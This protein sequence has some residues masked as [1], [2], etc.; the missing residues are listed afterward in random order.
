[1]TTLIKIQINMR[2]KSH[3]QNPSQLHHRSQRR[4]KRRKRRKLPGA[5][6]SEVR[7]FQRRLSVAAAAAADEGEREVVNRPKA[8]ELSPLE[9]HFPPHTRF[10]P[11][12]F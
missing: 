5:F 12:I 4:I 7:E 10:A 2:I 6:V 9:L 11:S 1:M 8:S 3:H